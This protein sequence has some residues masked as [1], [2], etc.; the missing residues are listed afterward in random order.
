MAGPATNSSRRSITLQSYDQVIGLSQANIN[1]TLRRHFSSLDARDELGRFKAKLDLVSINAQVLPPTV[2]LVDKDNADGALYI[3]HLGEGYYS[4]VVAETGGD[5]EDDEESDSSFKKVMIPT[6]G[7]ELAFDID[8]AFKPILKIPEMIVRQVPLP[9]G[10]SVQQLMINFGAVT[11]IVQLDRGRSKFPIPAESKDKIDATALE[12]GME[13]FHKTYL[14]KKLSMR[15][16]HNILGFAVKVDEAP[17][18]STAHFL[19][20]DSK[21]QIVGHRADGKKESFRQD[22][23]YNA[24]CFTEMT[25]RRMMPTTEIQYSGNWFYDSI[26]G[27]LVMSRSLFWDTFM[28]G[29]IKKAHVK[30]VKFSAAILDMLASDKFEGK[31]WCL[32]DSKPTPEDMCGTYNGTAAWGNLAYSTS[33]KSSELTHWNRSDSNLANFW[34]SPRTTVHTLAQP[35]TRHGEMVI[36]QDVEVNWEEGIELADDFYLTPITA[37]AAK[38]WDVCIRGS[39]KLAFETTISF[40]SISDI[41]GL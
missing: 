1:E 25:D 9:S 3:I 26:G 18:N 21:V 37:L 17:K 8:F 11:R 39:L 41:G 22:N 5:E 35:R 10:Y 15:E 33:Y 4:T 13:L 30:A 2:E 14:N 28:I 24:F 38:T 23:P 12:T 27:S 32:D 36:Q 29:K 34:S 40:K 31:G 6:N 20:T 7:W 16:G 19:P